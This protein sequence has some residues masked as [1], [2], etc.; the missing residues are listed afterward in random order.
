MSYKRLLRAAQTVLGSCM[1]LS[2]L[3]LRTTGLK[4]TRQ[5]TK[6]LSMW[7]SVTGLRKTQFF[8]F[9]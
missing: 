9:F 1:Q 8:C 6:M 7:V 5:T 4:P 3:R 2:E